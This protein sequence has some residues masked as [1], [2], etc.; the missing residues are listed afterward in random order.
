MPPEQEERG[1]I[2]RTCY[3]CGDPGHVVRDCPVPHDVRSFDV[4]D[5]VV[6][7]LGSE[8]L[9]ELVARLATSGGLPAVVEEP[10]EEQDFVS[11]NE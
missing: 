4:L 6:R 7:Q 3:R 9:E 11:R 2:R 1:T 5:E 8:L 10:E